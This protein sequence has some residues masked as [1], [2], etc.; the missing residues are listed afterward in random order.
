MRL[1]TCL[2][3]LL[4][5]QSCIYH[6]NALPSSFLSDGTVVH[7]GKPFFPLG[8]YA[9]NEIVPWKVV[10]VLAPPISGQDLA[11]RLVKAGWNCVVDYG[12]GTAPWKTGSRVNPD[13]IKEF[14]DGLHNVGMNG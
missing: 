12:V 14:F 7:G 5:V 6:S 1:Q 4:V 3:A 10:T 8:L 13:L 11:Q 2:P 9:E